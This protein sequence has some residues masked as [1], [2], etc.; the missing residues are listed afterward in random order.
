M[1]TARRAARSGSSRAAVGKPAV[2]PSTDSPTIWVAVGSTPASSSRSRRGMPRHTALPTRSPADLVGHARE[3][4][5]LLHQVAP[6][7]VGVGEL[8]LPVDQAG[9]AQRPAVGVDGRGL[10][11]GVDAVE[12]GVGHHVGRE[13]VDGEAVGRGDLADGGGRQGRREAGRGGPQRAP[14]LLAERPD[15]GQHRPGPGTPGEDV[16]PGGGD[17]GQAVVGR[18]GPGGGRGRAPTGRPGARTGRAGA[19]TWLRP[20]R[21]RPPRRADPGPPSPAGCATSPPGRAGRTG[22]GRRRP[23]PAG[24]APGV[25]GRCRGGGPRGRSPRPGRP[26][27]WCRTGRWP[28]S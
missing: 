5:H 23:S 8:Q 25:P 18:P 13:P 26:C 3:G 27:R 28:G 16:A 1:P 9:D 24:A 6:Q 20:R 15:G 12:V 19:P 14:G 22:P 2:K 7:Q 10:E 11:G 4:D 17:R 21:R